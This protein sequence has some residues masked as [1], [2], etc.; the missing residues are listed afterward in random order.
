VAPGKPVSKKKSNGHLNGNSIQT[1]NGTAPNRQSP[2]AH[3]QHRH[4]TTLH[5]NSENDSQSDGV[6]SGYEKL[7]ANDHHRSC[8][9]IDSD[10]HEISQNGR[11]GGILG[12]ETTH[13]SIDVNATGVPG[14]HDSL[15]TVVPRSSFLTSYPLVDTL[16]LLIILLQVPPAFL[17]II[18]FIF[19]L[20]T[21]IPPSSTMASA[22]AT[23]LPSLNELFHNFDGGPSTGTIV[24]VD[25]VA[26]FFAIFLPPSWRDSILDLAQAV[27]AITLGGG[28]ATGGALWNFM[29]CGFIIVFSQFFKSG[30]T[31]GAWSS[32]AS[33]WSKPAFDVS[34]M[35]IRS[36]KSLYQSLVAVHI[37]AQWL[38]KVVRRRIQPRDKSDPEAAAGSQIH[39]DSPI[40]IESSNPS[41]PITNGSPSPL[42]PGNDKS[43][44]GKK[45]RKQGLQIR[46]QQPLWA[47]LA[48][49][50]VHVL[51]SS[52]QSLFSQEAAKSGA[53]SKSNLGTATFTS[54]LEKVWITGIG[55]IEIAFCASYF[56]SGEE[57]NGDNRNPGEYANRAAGVDKTKPFYVRVNKADWASTI[58]SK[59]QVTDGVDDAPN[60]WIGKITGLS[61][62][63][64]YECEFVRVEGDVVVYST[65]I[66]TSTIQRAAS[67]SITCKLPLFHVVVQCISVPLRGMHPN[68]WVRCF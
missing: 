35:P 37:L 3:T 25:I 24:L 34:S 39:T 56:Q 48:N 11:H 33:T 20:L 43:T 46:S 8:S 18:Q 53:T 31:Y 36:S 60:E 65:N 13:R 28:A 61:P 12:L 47:A 15:S 27:I 4:P 30:I 64:N 42:K 49:T 22:A 10:T 17:F 68:A 2:A 44:A 9:D 62:M 19:S 16:T 58:I 29:L 57:Y 45:R 59:R 14:I 21:H 26:T 50:K 6:T 51:R 38:L 5:Q 41:T 52:E 55:S 63:S 66:T 67:G 23:T 40:N 32:S 7:R 1:G 54:E